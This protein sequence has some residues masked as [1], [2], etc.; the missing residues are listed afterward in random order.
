MGAKINAVKE[1]FG[2]STK[3]VT[4][5]I[6][7]QASK[8]VKTVSDEAMKDRQAAEAAYGKANLAINTA[9]TKKKYVMP[10][11]EVL[12]LDEK[13]MNRINS[14]KRAASGK[15][16]GGD[17]T[18]GSGDL[19]GGNDGEN[20]NPDDIFGPSGARPFQDQLWDNF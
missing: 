13:V 18:G 1:F 9:T 12:E 3:K 14:Y 5:V 19:P 4:N 16:G 2:F 20:V 11:G 10:N 7:E 6:K 15:T 17:W 8:E